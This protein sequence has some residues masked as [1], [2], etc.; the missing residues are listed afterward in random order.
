MDSYQNEVGQQNLRASSDSEQRE[1]PL[2]V[3]AK[4]KSYGEKF[5]EHLLEQYKIYVEMMDRVS[6]RRLQNNTFIF[7]YFL[8]Y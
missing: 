5:H 7:Y 6:A 3:D 2:S 8:V 1:N 4:R